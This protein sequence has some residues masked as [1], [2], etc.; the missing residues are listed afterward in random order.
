MKIKIHLDQKRYSSKPQQRDIIE[1]MVYWE[2]DNCC[3]TMLDCPRC[4]TDLQFERQWH[5]VRTYRR[6][7]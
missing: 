7:E 1:I 3:V 4:K 6:I 2:K 5:F